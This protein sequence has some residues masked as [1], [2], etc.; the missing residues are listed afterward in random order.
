M[1]ISKTL[2]YVGGPGGPPNC[3]VNNVSLEPSGFDLTR[4][5]VPLTVPAGSERTLILTFATPA[6]SYAGGL[7]IVVHARAS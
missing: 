4:S 7:T 6:S 3:S 5:N 2:E 1:T